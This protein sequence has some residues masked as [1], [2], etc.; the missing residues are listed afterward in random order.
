MTHEEYT[1]RVQLGI[2]Y[3]N[4]AYGG[5]TGLDWLSI[6]DRITLDMA[7]DTRCVL[8]QVTGEFTTSPL[9]ETFGADYAREH[10]F[11]LDSNDIAA[12]FEYDKLTSAW[13]ERINELQKQRANLLLQR[14]NAGLDDS[15][16]EDFTDERVSDVD[17]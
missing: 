14:A 2:E 8:G 7:R 17:G 4:S 12:G 5:V 10:G 6:V 13:Q 3:L 1:K 15:W 9:M 11:Y 16:L